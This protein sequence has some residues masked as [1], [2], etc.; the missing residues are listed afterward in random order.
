MVSKVDLAIVD[1]VRERLVRILEEEGRVQ[2]QRA[3]RGGGGDGGG[4]PSADM[5]FIELSIKEGMGV[6]D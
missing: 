5:H 3:E 2:E 6:E 4:A 1:G